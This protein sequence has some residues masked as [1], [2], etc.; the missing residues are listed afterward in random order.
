MFDPDRL[1]QTGF[2]VISRPRLDPTADGDGGPGR[3]RQIRRSGRLEVQ[4]GADEITVQIRTPGLVHHHGLEGVRR[5][6]VQLDPARIGQT[7]GHRHAVDHAEI[8]FG[9]QAAIGGVQ[10]LAARGRVDAAD[11]GPPGVDHRH[12]RQVAQGFRQV[13]RPAAL[14]VLARKAAH[15][16]RRIQIR[17]QA[18]GDLAGLRTAPPHLYGLQVRSRSLYRGRRR[19]PGPGDDDEGS[20]VHPARREPRVGQGQVES[21]RRLEPPDD[22]AAPSAFKPFRRKQDLDASLPR[23]GPQRRSQR[24]GGNIEDRSPPGGRH[25]RRQDR[26]GQDRSA[27]RP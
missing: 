24:L 15:R 1:A 22:G 11:K 14:H 27:D 23:Q 13:L 16:R 4:G 8:V 3:A 7:L 19:Q 10:T 12:A 2:A 18:T 21:T 6:Q 9:V 26:D 17:R 25:R 5:Q 20:A